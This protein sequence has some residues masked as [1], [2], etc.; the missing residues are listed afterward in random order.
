MVLHLFCSRVYPCV[1]E[2]VQLL[3]VFV[4]GLERG[5]QLQSSLGQLTLDL[6]QELTLRTH[7]LLVLRAPCSGLWPSALR[8]VL[9]GTS[10]Y[11]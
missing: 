2:C 7:S 4:L 11:A 5:L 9:M 6:L 8:L 1:P 10:S 3:Q